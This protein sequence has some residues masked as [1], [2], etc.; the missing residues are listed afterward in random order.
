[1]NYDE[2][3]TANQA[4]CDRVAATLL[5]GAILVGAIGTTIGA[6]ASV[7]P[8]AK[9]AKCELKNIA[10]CV[11]VFPIRTMVEIQGVDW[12]LSLVDGAKRELSLSAPVVWKSR[13]ICAAG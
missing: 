8:Q 1:M 7:A 4:N 12:C 3:D 5:A 2:M 10:T 13:K 11:A 9:P 6:L